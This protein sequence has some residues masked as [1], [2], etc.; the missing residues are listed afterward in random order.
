MHRVD[1]VSGRRREKIYDR[2]ATRTGASGGWSLIVWLGVVGVFWS[3]ATPAVAV[4]QQT[5]NWCASSDS[6]GKSNL[7]WVFEVPEFR[8]G[9]EV[10]Y[11]STSESIASSNPLAGVIHVVGIDVLGSD[12]KCS[13]LRRYVTDVL[14]P[15]LLRYSV[16]DDRWIGRAGVKRIIL[17]GGLKVVIPGSAQTPNDSREVRAAIPDSNFTAPE[18]NTLYLDIYAEGKAGSTIAYKKHV[19]HHELFHLVDQIALGEFDKTGYYRSSTGKSL[20]EAWVAL[21]PLGF[22]YGSSGEAFHTFHPSNHDGFVSGYGQDALKEDQAELF[23]ILM[24]DGFKFYSYKQGED[25]QSALKS[26]VL[27]RQGKT[28]PHA[29]LLSKL[30]RLANCTLPAYTEVL[31]G[32]YKSVLREA[33]LDSTQDSPTSCSADLAVALVIDVSGSMQEDNRLVRAVAAAK[34][35][36][37]AMEDQTLMSISAFSSTSR[38]VMPNTPAGQA[39]QNAIVA[40]DSLRPLQKTNIESGLDD[41]Y[42]QLILSKAPNCSIILLTDGANN[43]GDPSRAVVRFK[44][45]SSGCRGSIESVGLGKGAYPPELIA[46]SKSTGGSYWPASSSNVGSIYQRIAAKVRNEST[47]LDS[48]DLLGEGESVELAMK[49]APGTSLLGGSFSWQGSTLQTTLVD[50]QGHEFGEKEILAASG[51][52]EVSDTTA[53]L[54]LPNPAPGDWKVRLHWSEPPDHPEVVHIV[55]TDRSAVATNFLAFEPEYREGQSV[56]IRIQAAEVQ[57]TSRIPL[58]AASVSVEIQ[59]PPGAGAANGET[60]G[61]SGSV[62]PLLRTKKPGLLSNQNVPKATVTRRLDL[63]REPFAAG[64]QAIDASFAAEFLE[65]GAPGPYI[66]RATIRGKLSDGTTVEKVIY[67]SF[68]VGPLANNSM[69]TA[70]MHNVL[71]RS[72]HNSLLQGKPGSGGSLLEVPKTKNPLL[73]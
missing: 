64:V 33:D 62:N 71:L 11:V 7:D 39:R 38:V 24:A 52:Y 49:I 56:Q 18:A 41:G 9:L 40:L 44:N 61:A 30:Y 14:N 10:T 57:G 54:T 27:K 47:I 17:T 20:D 60:G 4:A 55:I 23:A 53:L 6:S 12:N 3:F 2:E 50:P 21:N 70:A 65:S 29:P 31:S 32:Y 66:V 35:N 43:I 15:E 22:S 5:S 28:I 48:V 42:S 34:A 59:L 46:L 63:M 72:K 69:R 67:S 13:D 25:L 16:Q 45:R 51:R 58:E 68:Q 19:F 37:R 8:S 36:I 26:E 73:N 1:T